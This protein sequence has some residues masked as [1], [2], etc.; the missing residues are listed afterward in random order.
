MDLKNETSNEIGVECRVEGLDFPN[1]VSFRSHIQLS[2][3][4]EDRYC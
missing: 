2:N 1:T 3:R 4:T